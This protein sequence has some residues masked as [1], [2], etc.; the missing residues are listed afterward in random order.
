[1]RNCGVSQL[2]AKMRVMSH[3]WASHRAMN[4]TGETHIMTT[5]YKHGTYSIAAGA[6]QEY[7]FWWGKGSKAP[8]E[9]FDVSIAPHLSKQEMQPIQQTGRAT[10]W[11]HRGGVGVVLILTLHNPNNVEVTFEA[12]HVHIY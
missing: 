12:N 6:T 4:S 3:G 8:N 9:F 2:T 1:M 10:Y 7:T 5:E 11:D